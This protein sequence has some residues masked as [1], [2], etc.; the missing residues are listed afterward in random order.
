MNRAEN[1]SWYDNVFWNVCQLYRV[2][3]V[4][5]LGPVEAAEVRTLGVVPGACA[6]AFHHPFVQLA[7]PSS[8]SSTV[9]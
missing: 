9:I 7:F 2:G 8:Y 1:C 3:A 6:P 5:A 4:A